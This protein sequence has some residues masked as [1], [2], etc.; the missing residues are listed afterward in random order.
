MQHLIEAIRYN[1]DRRFPREELEEIISKKDEAIPYLLEIMSELQKHPELAE[2]ASRIDFL[3]ASYL[4]SQFRVMELFPILIE[5]F[6]LPEDVCDLIF[7]DTLTDAGGRMLASVYNGDFTLL[8]QLIE[9]RKAS[10]YARG[11]GLRALAILV[12]S[13]EIPRETAVSY[14]GEL[15]TSKRSDSDDYFNAEIVCCAD[16]LYPEEVYADIK[17]LYEDRAIDPHVI[18]LDEIQST[19]LKDKDDLLHTKS[20][21]MESE[22][23]DDTIKEM[24]NWDC[25]GPE[26]YSSSETL[27][28]EAPKSLRDLK[29]ITVAAKPGRNDPCSC[30]SGLKYKKCC[31]K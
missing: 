26:W 29:T 13:G 1:K 2:D 17:K 24:E 19:L 31:G 6:S 7:S 18:Q 5:L 21:D 27:K 20:K 4:L 10:Q 16:D 11:Q 25:F 30:G 8:Q 3:Y 9:N 23:I 15:L 28:Y 22:R 12:Y 14:L